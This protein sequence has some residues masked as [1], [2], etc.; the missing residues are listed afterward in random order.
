MTILTTA[1]ERERVIRPAAVLK[2]AAPEESRSDQLLPSEPLA[3]ASQDRTPQDREPADLVR[4]VRGFARRHTGVF[5]IAALGVG[6]VAFGPQE[7]CQLLAR[8]MAAFDGKI[9]Q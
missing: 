8:V 6:I 3:A 1:H 2:K 5:L 4:E 7:G 9:D